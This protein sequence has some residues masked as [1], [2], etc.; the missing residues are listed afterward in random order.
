MMSQ[1]SQILKGSGRSLEWM[2]SKAP[3]IETPRDTEHRL[4][5]NMLA[6]QAETPLFFI[7]LPDIYTN[8]V[9]TRRAISA[10]QQGYGED[11][12]FCL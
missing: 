12:P 11:R 7:H 9:A 1:R 2:T 6:A 10:T 3:P 8:P 4:D 5:W